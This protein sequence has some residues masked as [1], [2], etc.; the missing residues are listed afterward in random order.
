MKILTC[1]QGSTE[2]ALA[3][4][5]VVSASEADAL[6]TPLFKPREGEGVKSYLYRKA[7]ERIMGPSVDQGG[8]FA[9]EQGSVLEKLALP[10]YEFKY[11]VTVDR[12]GFC[13]SDDGK[14]GCSPDGLIGEQCGM[15]I[16][17]PTA[18]VHCRYLLEQRVPLD[19]L[20]QVHFSMYVTGRPEWVFVSYSPYLP[21][22]VVHVLR[23]EV[24]Q[25][26]IRETLAKFIPQLDDAE[27]RIRGIM[28]QARR[29]A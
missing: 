25:N 27:N 11:G 3:R 2:W 26:V 12:V 18:P 23:D 13:V 6:F 7:A 1:K 14:V 8:T 15:E 9:M 4:A 16:K 17:C 28:P 10:W 20:P 22:L 19:Y 29:D 24:I 5:G 21:P